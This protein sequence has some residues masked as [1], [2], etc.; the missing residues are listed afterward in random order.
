LIWPAYGEADVSW[1]LRLAVFWGSLPLAALGLWLI[2]R[3]RLRRRMGAAVFV[4]LLLMLFVQ[5][6]FIEPQRLTVRETHVPLGVP[7]RIALIADAHLGVYK[8]PAFLQR[9]VEQ[10]NALDVDAVLIAGDH[11][12]LPDR[13][14][15]ELL[16]PLAALRHPVYSVPGNHDE[17]MPGPP[18][19]A[20]LKAALQQH[21]VQ[22]IEGRHVDMGT[23]YL[24]GLGDLMAGKARMEALR[25][26]PANKPRLVLMHNPDTALLLPA[27]SAA[28]ALAGHTHCGQVRIPGLYRAMIPT[29]APFDR[30]LQHLAAVPTFVTCGLGEVKLPLRLFN[31][32]VIDVLDLH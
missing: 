5:A 22:T 29:V 12:Y 19:A 32:P 9:V 25:G 6:R 24:V 14:L 4:L 16:A 13:P 20:A 7:T 10:L 3:L 1:F 17:Q 30:G 11:T 28:L 23:H 27:G 26:T 2:W 18:L 8:G 21:G 31:P 15:A